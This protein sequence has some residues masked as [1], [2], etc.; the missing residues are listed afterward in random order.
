MT[1]AP[2]RRRGLRF[3]TI[4]L[5]AAILVLAFVA[6]LGIPP[7]VH[8]IAVASIQSSLR[9]PDV[10]EVIVGQVQI[11]W[12]GP[13]VVKDLQV[14]YHDDVP[15]IDL[16]VTVDNGLIPLA[17]G[18]GAIRIEMGG[19]VVV[20]SAGDTDDGGHAFGIFPAFDGS[21]SA[22]SSSLSIPSIELLV[23]DLQITLRGEDADE[24]V[25][26]IKD[27]S[28]SWQSHGSLDCSVEVLGTHG[29]AAV[30]A[31]IEGLVS[32][33]GVP[34]PM[35]STGSLR[36][37]IDSMPIPVDG[38]R[39][40]ESMSIH[41]SREGVE[42]DLRLDGSC[43]LI[44][45]ADQVVSIDL[46]VSTDPGATSLSDLAGRV[47]IVGVSDSLLR[48]F[49]GEHRFPV[50]F[51]ASASREE[52]GGAVVVS[53]SGAGI[54]A[55]VSG[56]PSWASESFS[57]ER[58]DAVVQVQGRM[59]GDFIETELEG[60]LGLHVEADQVVLHPTP[61]V[62]GGRIAATGPLG[63]RS[64]VDGPSVRLLSSELHVDAAAV[65]SSP[66]IDIHG[67]M[68]FDQ[69]VST[70]RGSWN[71]G[72][73]D[74]VVKSLPTDAIDLIADLDG[75]L[76]AS[77]GSTIDVIADG[78]IIDFEEADWV[79]D[80]SS[81][82]ADLHAPLQ[83]RGAFFLTPDGET[84][85]GTL[86]VTPRT[87]AGVLLR[88]G[89]GLSDIHGI[90]DPIMLEIAGLKLPVDGAVSTL[91]ADVVVT[92]GEVMIDS[93]AEAFSI[94]DSLFAEA[95]SSFP[96]RLDPI[97]FS[98]DQ[99][100]LRYEQFVMHV[101]GDRIELR[102]SVDLNTG[103]L[104]LMMDVPVNSLGMSVKELRLATAAVAGEVSITGTTSNPIVQFRP[105]LNPGGIIKATEINGI[106]DRI[107]GNRGILEG[108]G[109]LFDR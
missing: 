14:V 53:I 89:P 98:I 94:L 92:V 75:M 69:G 95:R 61:V 105:V 79:L 80:L 4:S 42:S 57:I 55:T 17:L 25:F 50:P 70:V 38:L 37:D 91:D 72:K 3:W 12:S 83:R 77:L 44:D 63:I 104:N 66:A 60:E 29:S 47:S 96:A 27:A 5:S 45:S 106:L 93:R 88:L 32:D 43:R 97:R 52:P 54:D 18:G 23:P 26:S 46:D 87:I 99:G 24:R 11:S 8:S 48:S 30:T 101:N 58:V 81:P 78:S 33:A 41:C 108:L 31:S 76:A 10:K 9:G 102:G 67:S 64:T 15:V 84:I 35:S 13:Q 103:I 19:E 39:Q 86:V 73:A 36:V 65:N 90:T 7:L 21:T 16:S 22:S 6:W 56:M 62:T 59:M 109:G 1:S 74:L 40:V 107:P 28:A 68:T 71:Q 34:S 85:N 49:A 20:P 2:R 100:V 82:Q 51:D